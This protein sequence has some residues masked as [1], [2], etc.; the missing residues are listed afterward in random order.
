L[1]GTDSERILA[2]SSRLL[3]D[4]NALARMSRRAF[5]F[6]DGRAG[7]KIAALIEKWL[8]RRALSPIPSICPR[9]IGD[10]HHE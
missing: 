9:Q 1:V 6:G 7:E 4:P 3:A 10:C 8:E 2:E 5:P